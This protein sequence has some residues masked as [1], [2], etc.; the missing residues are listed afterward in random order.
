MSLFARASRVYVFPEPI[1]MRS[2][3]EKLAHLVKHCFK[4]E[5]NQGHLY[6]F[7]GKNRRR[8]KILFYD[9]SG[10]MLVVKRMEKH[11]FMAV[12]E[13]QGRSEITR[14]ELRFLLH[15]SVLRVYTPEA[16]GAD[17]KKA[18]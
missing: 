5:V 11:A 9:G 18:A 6:V 8:L 12:T 2:G 10:L 17:L 3:F 1:D 14:R 7:L 16:Q 4:A 15:G 13:L